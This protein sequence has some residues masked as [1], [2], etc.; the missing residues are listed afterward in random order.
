M[1]GCSVFMRSIASAVWLYVHVRRYGYAVLRQC[2]Q[3]NSAQ[4]TDAEIRVA[5]EMLWVMLCIWQRDDRTVITSDVARTAI[6]VTGRCLA[7]A[8]GCCG[9]LPWSE[10]EHTDEPFCLDSRQE[11]KGTALIR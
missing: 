7:G 2:A 10:H 5:F 11:A 4:C 3:R 9:K 8:R 6:Q 1:D